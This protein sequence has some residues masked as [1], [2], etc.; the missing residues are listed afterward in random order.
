MIERRNSSTSPGCRYRS[1][2][3]RMSGSREHLDRPSAPIIGSKN[4][5][6]NEA[7]HILKTLAVKADTVVVEE[8][9]KEADMGIYVCTYMYIRV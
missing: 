2:Y 9:E 8:K 4:R 5:R 6:R 1:A 3:C 7:T